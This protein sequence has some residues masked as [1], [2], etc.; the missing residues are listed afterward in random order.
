MCVSRLQIE[1]F[2]GIKKAELEFSGHTLLIGGNNVGK[3]TI[4][5]ALDLVLG[6]DRLNRTPPVEEFDFRNAGY[7]GEDGETPV[8]IRIEVVLTDLTEDVKTL[9]AVNLEFWHRTVKRLLGEGE[10]ANVDDPNVEPCL[11]LITVAQYD[12][13]EDQFYAKTIYGR[14]DDDNDADPRSAPTKVK[15]ASGSSTCGPSGPAR[16]R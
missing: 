9:C 11:R 13:E 5:E 15:R 10:I 3:S 7:L 4:C 16:G 14:S 12:V 1:N 6:P 2:R 8:P